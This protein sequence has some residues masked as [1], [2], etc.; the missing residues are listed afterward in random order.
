MLDRLMKVSGLSVGF[1]SPPALKSIK[2]AS[3]EQAQSL[4]PFKT[5][6]PHVV[7]EY[8]GC[9]D[10]WMHGSADSSSYFVPVKEGSGMWFDFNGCSDHTHDVA[11]VLSI[12]GVNPITGQKQDKMR[13]EQYREKCPVH[14]V[15][16]KQ[17]R[18]CEKC[19]YK[20]P[21]QSYMSTTGTPSGLFWLDGFRSEDGKVRQYIFTAEELRGVA[22][23]IIGKDKVYAIGIAFYLSKEKKPS[24]P[25]S[26]LRSG[27]AG[28]SDKDIQDTLDQL[29]QTG[30]DPE[31]TT[32]THQSFEYS[33]MNPASSWQT[34]GTGNTDDDSANITA[35]GYTGLGPDSALYMSE[36][37]GINV[38]SKPIGKVKS[39]AKKLEVA[40][41]ATIDQQIYDDPKGLDHWDDNPAGFLYINYA[42]QDTV[43][44]IL[45]KGKRDERKEG[46]LADIN[47]GN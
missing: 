45:N 6:E 18:F 17:D 47:T 34:L 44:A 1:N 2:T 14:S 22:E 9:P 16:F 40:A 25:K 32:V 4:P 28:A 10:S 42:S 43:D 26:I 39:L 27:G 38:T 46:Y 3:G 7:D 41:G 37:R 35:S 29:S 23:Q 31:F 13:L 8:S 30:L 20:W 11:V 24:P 33:P 36:S 21:A 5:I 19:K 15:E 12:Q